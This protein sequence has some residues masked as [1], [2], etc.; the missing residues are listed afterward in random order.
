MKVLI[1]HSFYSIDGGENK[2][3][4][5]DVEMFKSKGHEVMLYSKKNVTNYF[6]D[7]FELL[8]SP[9]NPF[10][11]F[12]LKR[13][14]KRFKPDVIHIH[15]T[16]YKLGPS[17]YLA[18]KV[19]NVK[20]FQS[21]H[22]L[23][24]FCANAFM[25]RN[26]NECTKCLDSKIFSIK[27]SCYKNR[28][29][30]AMSSL[31]YFI[32]GKISLFTQS[33]FYFFSPNYYFDRL[34]KDLYGLEDANII[35]FPNYVKDFQLIPEEKMRLP[36]KYF[37]I[38]GRNSNEKGLD[39]F[40]EL[41]KSINLDTKLVIVSPD[42]LSIGNKNII[43]LKNISD[44]QL[45]YIYKN[46]KCVIIPSNW[47][48]GF[49]RVIIETSSVNKPII[50]SD[51]IAISQLDSLKEY[52]LTFNLESRETLEKALEQLDNKTNDS[53]FQFRNWYIENFSKD[54]YLD[55]ILNEYKATVK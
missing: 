21:L 1:I 8:I 19:S 10:V 28:V 2:R 42:N 22:N 33:N 26:G 51:K 44:E 3:V 35:K 25:L 30:S 4:L 20:L 31:H 53:E 54:A 24:F 5:E 40:L 12:Q 48:E 9:F 11:Y 32:I 43:Y 38:V 37:L 15:N 17:A 18:V 55:N 45:A 34:I 16:W 29:L 13:L 46:S 49:P 39:K 52:A 7:I 47:V 6:Q 23:R 27:Y 50:M 14:L 41:W 36:T